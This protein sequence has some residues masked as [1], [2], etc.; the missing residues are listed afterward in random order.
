[1]RLDGPA[2]AG[3]AGRGRKEVVR[4]DGLA[5]ASKAGRGLKEVVRLT[6]LAEADC[7]PSPAIAGRWARR[8]RQ[9]P[10]RAG[11]GRW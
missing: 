11:R 6:G 4:L 8:G 5:E 9:E 2:E 3:K 7:Q 1:M 10:V